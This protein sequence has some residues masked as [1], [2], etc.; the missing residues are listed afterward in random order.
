MCSD[1][2]IKYENAFFW[3]LYIILYVFLS[4]KNEY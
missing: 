2:N 3:K 4:D 1:I